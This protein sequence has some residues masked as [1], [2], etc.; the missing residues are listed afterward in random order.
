MF[1]GG[2]VATP[3]GSGAASN[4][5]QAK[6]PRGNGL[7]ATQDDNDE[8]MELFADSIDNIFSRLRTLESAVGF[9]IQ[10]LAEKAPITSAKSQM[11]AYNDHVKQQGKGHNMGSPHGDGAYGL[12]MSLGGIT[13][14]TSDESDELTAF[15]SEFSDAKKMGRAI[16]LFRISQCYDKKYVK[17]R[18]AFSEDLMWKH[19]SIPALTKRLLENHFGG[20]LKSGDAPRGPR[21]RKIRELWELKQQQKD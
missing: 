21:E 8:K 12:Y 1:A 9:T 6:R 4:G 7:A 2:L 18:M 16:T 20:D 5:S 17:I 11:G 15:A 3:I 13:A 19:S 14:L 10:M